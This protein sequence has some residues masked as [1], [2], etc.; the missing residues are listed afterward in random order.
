MFVS[1][2]HALNGAELSPIWALVGSNVIELRPAC[3]AVSGYGA[4]MTTSLRSK[5]HEFA[6][7]E[8]V[9]MIS[10]R[11]ATMATG[12]KVLR[13][14]ISAVIV[15]V[16]SHKR[17]FLRVSSGYPSDRGST[18]MAR[19]RSWSNFFVEKNSMFWDT[20]P[21]WSCEWMR[22]RCDVFVSGHAV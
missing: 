1:V 10:S 14:I 12:Y 4:V 15:D 9:R 16:I 11:I 5:R 13:R 21:I 19:M 18:P 7:L 22:S 17:T 2:M 6:F 20:V 3:L 8:I